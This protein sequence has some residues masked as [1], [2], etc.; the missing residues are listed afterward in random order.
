MQACGPRTIFQITARS[1]VRI[2]EFNRFGEDEL[3]LLP[4]TTL[5]VQV[6]AHGTFPHS[7]TARAHVSA[8]LLGA[9]PQYPHVRAIACVCVHVPGVLH[10]T[11]TA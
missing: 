6:G 9:A 1:L 7:A 10:N 8:V 11:T 4:G 5:Q 3:V 2:S